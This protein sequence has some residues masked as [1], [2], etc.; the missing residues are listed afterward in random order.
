MS[1]T[2]PDL[3]RPYSTEA[4]RAAD[5]EGLLSYWDAIKVLTKLASQPASEWSPQQESLF[6]RSVQSGPPEPPQQRLQRWISLYRDEIEII[7]NVR[8]RLVHEGT[9]TDPELR[10]A[11]Y[12]ARHIISTVMGVQPSQADPEWAFR[13]LAPAAS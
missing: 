5:R 4:D 11:S 1:L 2:P 8:N 6:P 9:V 3:G 7:R 13:K 12:L 10:G